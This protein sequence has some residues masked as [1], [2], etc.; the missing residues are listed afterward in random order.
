MLIKIN[1]LYSYYLQEK[2][3]KV[4]FS[5]FLFTIDLNHFR[6][7][8]RVISGAKYISTN[9]QIAFKTDLALDPIP[10]TTE[11]FTRRE[12]KIMKEY[13]P[14]RFEIED[15]AEIDFRCLLR[16][17]I[18]LDLDI[19]EAVAEDVLDA[20]AFEKLINRE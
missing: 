20:E 8:G 19:I 4:S 10:F 3:A 1:K 13:T 18:D 15:Q 12:L 6:Q 11:L 5:E 17:G 14:I 9:A 16:K 7:T 2:I